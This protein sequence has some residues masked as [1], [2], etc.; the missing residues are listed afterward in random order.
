MNKTI[1][2][3]CYITY[4]ERNTQEITNKNTTTYNY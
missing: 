2:K 1:P 3:L 4:K